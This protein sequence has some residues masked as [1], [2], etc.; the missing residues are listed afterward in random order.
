MTGTGLS[1]FRDAFTLVAPHELSSSGWYWHA[2]NDLLEIL[3]TM[4]LVGAALVVVGLAVAVSR[5]VR[6]LGAGER[7]EDRAA[8]LA[9][10]GALT[11]VAVHS[12]FD[13]GLVMPANSVTLAIV[14][15]A[16]LAAQRTVVGGAEG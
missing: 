3:V 12:C 7:S 6:L 4:G 11:A 1:T 10:L 14:V 16:A 8:A 2:H 13:F 15:G 5:L 9:A